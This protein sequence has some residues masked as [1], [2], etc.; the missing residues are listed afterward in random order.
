MAV[1]LLGASSCEAKALQEVCGRGV[2]FEVGDGG[3]RR[4]AAGRAHDTIDT[5][6]RSDR[7]VSRD[8]IGTIGRCQ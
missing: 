2:A 1:G 6:L 5:T 7:V 3:G 4:Q 8:C